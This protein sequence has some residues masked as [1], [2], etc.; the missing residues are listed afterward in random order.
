[1]TNALT[2]E[3]LN[4]FAD[5]KMEEFHTPVS[6]NTEKLNEEERNLIDFSINKAWI[7]PKFKMKYFQAEDQLTPFHKLRQL[8]LELR[9]QEESIEGIEYVLK[10][11]STELRIVQLKKERA[12]DELEKTEWELR[13]IEIKRD[14]DQAKRRVAHN[15]IERHIYLDLIKDFLESDEG[16]S[17]DGK[18]LLE[19]FNTPLEDEYEKK[20]W[21]VRF[22]K[23]AAMDLLAYN[24]ISAGNMSAITTLPQDLQNE[25]YSIAHHYT[26]SMKN[27]QEVIKADMAKVLGMEVPSDR[28][29]LVPPQRKDQNNKTTLNSD[30]GNLEDVYNI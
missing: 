22:A 4:R 23:Q 24:S 25:V 26:L 15:Y 29:E 27:H 3:D 28:I 14:L 6:T 8:L 10:K 9:A 13:E 20:Y 11:L 16:K 5:Y 21:V 17:E 12:A 2:T 19:A 30:G 1:M 18:S 7:N